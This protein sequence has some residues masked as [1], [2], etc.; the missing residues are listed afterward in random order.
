[1]MLDRFLP[2]EVAA[3]I[4]NAVPDPERQRE[5]FAVLFFQRQSDRD[6]EGKRVAFASRGQV[7]RDGVSSGKRAA[8]P[9]VKKHLDE[10]AH[11]GRYYCVTVLTRSRTSWRG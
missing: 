9:L 2:D 8:A 1:M 6:E 10:F 7:A 11:L 3:E 5:Y 4:A